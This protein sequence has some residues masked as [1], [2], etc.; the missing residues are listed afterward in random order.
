[1][2]TESGEETKSHLVIRNARQTDEG[3]YT[4]KPSI[5]KSA[6]VKLYVLDGEFLCICVKYLQ[7]S[8]QPRVQ[9]QEKY[10]CH[11]LNQKLSSMTIFFQSSILHF[12]G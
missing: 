12:F 3:N 1:M 8:A 10:L 6:S 5:F 7:F 9:I 2:V 4:C 11:F